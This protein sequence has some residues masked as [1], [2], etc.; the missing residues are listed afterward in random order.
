MKLVHILEDRRKTCSPTCRGEYMSWLWKF[1]GAPSTGTVATEESKQK[2]RDTWMKNY[3]V[4]NAFL[5]KQQGNESSIAKK[6]YDTLKLYV[7]DDLEYE[8]LIESRYYADVQVK[9][10]KILVEFYGDYWHMNPAKYAD[11]FYNA[12]KH[13][14]AKQIRERDSERKRWLE[15]RGYRVIIVWE[16]D[17]HSQQESVLDFLRW[18]MS[19]SGAKV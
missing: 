3:G 9:A 16:S 14:T 12:K 5:V 7:R 13:Q 15:E 10:Q 11:D 18:S 6:F 1:Y 2:Q 8:Q 17:W 4:P 19:E